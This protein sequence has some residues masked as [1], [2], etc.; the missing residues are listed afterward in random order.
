MTKRA[1]GELELAILQILKSGERFT[2]KEVHRQLGSDDK[3]TTIMTVMSRLAEKK[4]LRRERIGL[5][6]EYWLAPPLGSAPS[7]LDQIKQKLF[8]FKTS[9]M[10]SY[11]LESADDVSDQDL[12]EI[13]QLIEL[14]KAKRSKH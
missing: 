14:E 3:Y 7:L 4:K 12:E 9:E 8:G 13:K 1:F 10:V 5:Q 6:Y 2:V 11:L